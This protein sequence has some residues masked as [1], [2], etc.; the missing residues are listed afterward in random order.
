MEI[1]VPRDRDNS[2]LPQ[3][4]KILFDSDSSLAIARARFQFAIDELATLLLC[5]HP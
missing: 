1:E 5:L 3:P 4:I 2:F